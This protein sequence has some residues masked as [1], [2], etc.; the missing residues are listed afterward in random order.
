MNG[1]EIL[2]VLREREH[3]HRHHLEQGVHG[4]AD[5]G[6]VFLFDVGAEEGAADDGEGE[7]HHFAIDVNDGA[8]G[9]AR[10]GANC[11]GRHVGGVADEAI[12]VEGGLDQAAL[13]KVGG[14]FV[15]QQALAEGAWRVGECGSS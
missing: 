4:L 8:I 15:G 11:E 13:A 1:E 12:A 5:D 9:V 7:S 2:Q 3:E 10:A 6:G 14:A